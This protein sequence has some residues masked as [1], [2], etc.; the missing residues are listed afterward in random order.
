M[1]SGCLG[2]EMEATANEN[3]FQST[4]SEAKRYV[5]RTKKTVRVYKEL[6]EWTFI[7]LAAPGATSIPGR[8]VVSWNERDAAVEVH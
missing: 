1:M 5:E 4:L 8:A 6:Q 2:C 3:G 7:E